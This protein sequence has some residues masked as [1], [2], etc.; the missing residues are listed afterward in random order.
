MFITSKYSG[1]NRHGEQCA[2][3][4]F[5]ILLEPKNDSGRY[6]TRSNVCATCGRIESAHNELLS[7]EVKEI[8]DKLRRAW[9]YIF[10]ARTKD[11]AEDSMDTAEVIMD[12]ARRVEGCRYFLPASINYPI[13]AIVRHTSMRQLGHFMMGFARVLGHRIT[14][15]GSYGGDGLTCTVPDAVYDA[16]IELPGE[17][18]EAWN[19]G[20][21]WNS[22]G[23]EDPMMRKWAL[24]NL[25]ALRG[26]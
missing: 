10:D 15:S 8:S 11:N 1:Y 21:G 13:R 20:G 14:L 12:A 4:L 26:R 3:G 9:R 7:G 5:L 6:P 2:A 16:G 23:S 18:R 22:S 24:E 19:N 25:Q 17:L